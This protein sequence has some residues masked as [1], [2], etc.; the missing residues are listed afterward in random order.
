MNQPK[1]SFAFAAFFIFCLSL[2]T[3]LAQTPPVTLSEPSFDI[4]LQTVV[5]SNDS[6]KTDV[7]PSLSGVIKKLKADFPFTNYRSVSTF[8]LKIKNKGSAGTRSV[9]FVTEKNLAV[10]PDWT[11]DDL[12]NSFDEKGQEAI[13][14]R[15][16]AFYQRIP[17]TSSNTAAVN[18]EQLGLTTGFSLAKNIPTVVGSLATSK[19]DEMMFLILTVRSAEK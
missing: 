6:G 3:A 2:T 12:T 18:Y 4:V 16:F 17:I 15:K 10:F 9:Y 11:I 8:I 13:Q 7:A 14:I 1:Q 19:P 5:G